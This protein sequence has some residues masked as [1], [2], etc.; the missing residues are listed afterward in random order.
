MKNPCKI[1]VLRG[2]CLFSP[3]SMRFCG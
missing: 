1:S 3:Y 2:F